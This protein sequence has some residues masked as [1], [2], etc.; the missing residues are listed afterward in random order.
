MGFVCSER[1]G[2]MGR[3]ARLVSA[4][5]PGWTKFEIRNP[6]SETNGPNL[7]GEMSETTRRA[8]VSGIAYLSLPFV[9]DFG[10][11]ISDLKAIQPW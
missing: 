3:G 11:R 6:K 1:V 4:T 10:F 2:G 8:G 7:E 9:S 5:K